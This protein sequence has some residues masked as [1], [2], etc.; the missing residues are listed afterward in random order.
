V[1]PTRVLVV[2]DEV[3]FAS[4]LSERL[5]L[6]NYDAKEAYNAG[7]ALRIIR[8]EPPDVVLLDLQMPEMNGLDALK[9]IKKM[10]PSVEV[11]MLTGRGDDR[12]MEEG[13]MS[14]A[15]EYVMKPID[16]GELVIKI[17]KAGKNRR[18]K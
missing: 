10:D 7:D 13:I 9:I 16:I 15:F 12:S 14:G 6:R 18:D 17:D 11:I 4:A 3:E 5:R 8:E 1:S 2:D